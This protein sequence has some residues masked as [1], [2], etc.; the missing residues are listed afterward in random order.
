VV[1]KEINS[2]VDAMAVMDG[3]EF[4]SKPMRIQFAKHD[5]QVI[6]MAK[7]QYNWDRWV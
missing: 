2:S 5:S 7:G 1:F 4:L 3:K 6:A